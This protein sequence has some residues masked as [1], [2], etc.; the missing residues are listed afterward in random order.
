MSKMGRPKAELKLASEEREALRRFVRGSVGVGST[1]ERFPAANRCRGCP[2]PPSDA[3]GS[4]GRRT[5]NERNRNVRTSSSGS[6]AEPVTTFE[7][8]ADGDL[9][10]SEPVTTFER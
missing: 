6:W 2:T 1:F 5:G 9:T 8:S 3:K 4:G 10:S 7:A